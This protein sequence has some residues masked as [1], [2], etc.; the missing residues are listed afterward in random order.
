M[1][2]NVLN[3]TIVMPDGEIIKTRQRAKKCSAGPDFGRYFIGALPVLH[4]RHLNA[5]AG[6]EG[7][8]GIVTE[9]TLKLAP[10]LPYSV[11]VSSFPTVE[12]AASCVRD[13]VQQGVNLQCIELLDDV[14]KSF[15]RRAELRGTTG[16]N[17]LRQ[18][19]ERRNPGRPYLAG[20][21]R[22]VPQVSGFRAGDEVRCPADRPAGPGEQRHQ[23]GV[24]QE[25]QGEGRAVVQP[26]GGAVVGS[27]LLCVLPYF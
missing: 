3:L 20:A 18:Q 24:C 10:I 19:A 7:T 17:P 6:S 4:A 8:L 23:I 2:D 16:P 26:E 13:L 12:A 5:R 14:S 22:A 9:A 15:R 25:R 11:G 27:G 21:A 1:R